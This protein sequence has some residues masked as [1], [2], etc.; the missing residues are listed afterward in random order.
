MNESEV[1]VH[2]LAHDEVPCNPGPAQTHENGYRRVKVVAIFIKEGAN[3]DAKSPGVRF[4]PRADHPAPPDGG[5]DSDPA[6][7]V[8]SA[9][10][11]QVRSLEPRRTMQDVL[12]PRRGYDAVRASDTR[13]YKYLM[14]VRSKYD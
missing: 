11:A 7:R 12:W 8:A 5:Y 2:I 14:S 1:W 9:I 13:D 10:T 6:T 3:V 4:K